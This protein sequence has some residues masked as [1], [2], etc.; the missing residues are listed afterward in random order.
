MAINM[1]VDTPRGQSAS[2][3]AN[4]SRSASVLSNAYSKAYVEWVQ[5]LANS[6]AWANQ[7]ENEKFQTTSLSYATAKEGE[8]N[9][10]NQAPNV[11]LNH[12]SL[13]A[14]LNNSCPTQGLEPSVLPYV[15]NQP[16]DSQLWDSNFCPILIFGMNEYLEGDTR[17]IMCS[18]HRIAAFVRQQKLE[19][20]TTEDISQ[21]SE[22]GYAAWD[23]LSSIY[24]SGWNKLEANKDKKY[25]RQC[26]SSQFN[27]KPLNNSN[28]RKED[29]GKGKP[30]NISR[31]FL[32]IPSRP[33]KS[34]L[35]KSKFY[36]GD[37]MMK[38]KSYAQASKE[39]INEIIKI[40]NSPKLSSN[41]ISEIYKAINNSDNKGKPKLNMMTKGSSQ[42]QIIISMGLNNVIRVMAQ[43]NIYITNINRS[44]KDI[45]SEVAVDFIRFDN[46]DIIVTTNKVAATSD[47]N[48]IKDYMKNLNN[49]DSSDMMSSRLLQSKS[50]LKILAIPYFVEDTNL[51]LTP[52][53]IE[54][55]LETTFI[56]V[57]IWDSQNDTKEK[58]LINKCFNIG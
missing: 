50:Y 47:L 25:F 18:L 5:A 23:F 6:P 29:K 35:A 12:A 57:D 8:N 9:S 17:N 14:V 16:V 44:P 11:D 28:L 32:P 7:V 52:D 38:P 26:V 13:E 31:V 2:S 36:K 19:D 54:K 3:S 53:I 10:T 22:F 40:K 39:D 48:I 1:E 24:E 56:W 20:K 34:V 4:S 41:K 49:V 27:R 45:K 43:S 42:K 55:V 21:I 30:V 33:S 37:Q 58:M 51:L 46:E 15:A